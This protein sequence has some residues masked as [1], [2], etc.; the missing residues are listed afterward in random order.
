MFLLITA[1]LVV[2]APALA[3]HGSARDG[4]YPLGYVGDTWTGTVTSTNDDT[5]EITLTYTKGDK[6]ESFTGVLQSGLKAKRRDGSETE[7]KPSDIPLGTR[8]VVYY[9]AQTKKVEGR[10]VKFYEIFRFTSVPKDS[11]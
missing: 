9:M 2:S 7:W 8:I 10:K 1:A 11:K 3:Q 5:R 6:T 4:Y